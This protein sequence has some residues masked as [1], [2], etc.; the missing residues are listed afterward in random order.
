[1]TRP[2]NPEPLVMH[3]K[4][5]M[6]SLDSGLCI[7][8]VKSEKDYKDKLQIRPPAIMT[9]PPMKLSMMLSKY[10]RGIAGTKSRKNSNEPNYSDLMKMVKQ[11]HS[12]FKS[13]LRQK[14]M[15]EEINKAKNTIKI[16][17][18]YR[19][20]KAHTFATSPRFDNF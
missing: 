18:P 17:G 9:Y 15:C 10:N 4:A 13:V 3:K 19:I 16:D 1:M 20:D 5:M 14:I 2:K 12:M 6:E 11:N 7:A 8:D